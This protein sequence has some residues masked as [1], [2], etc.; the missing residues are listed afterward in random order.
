MKAQPDTGADREDLVRPRL[1]EE[2]RLHRLE[3]L[4]LLRGEV[5]GL[6]EVGGQIVELPD[7]LARVPRGQPRA[8]G[9]PGGQRAERARV[10]AIVVDAPAAVV[11]EVLD[12]FP[13]G[14]L[15]V[16]KRVGHAG[17]VDRVLREPVDH[18]GRLDAENVVDRR[19]D[20]VDVVELR[21]RRPVGS[22]AR[23]PGDRQRCARAAEVRRDELRVREGRVA[24]PRPAGVIHVVH[25]RPAEC[26]EPPEPVQCLELL[27]DRV[28]NLVLGQ[29]LADAAVLALGAG[30]VVAPDIDHERVLADPERVQAVDEPAHLR[31]RVFDEAGE[32]LHQ[33]PLEGPL[34]LGD[35]RPRGHGGERAA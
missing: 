17:P 21:P 19:H 32:H 31:I 9:E 12:A 14:R 4:R 28:R 11:V 10:P 15:G 16:G 5:L 22:D 24:R 1:L 2:Q 25:L 23:G 3:P 30:A 27:R 29:Q 26:V 8:H 7:V 6:G 20:V 13:P 34:G 18:L 33:A 35:A